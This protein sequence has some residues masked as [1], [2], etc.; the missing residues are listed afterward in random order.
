M[1]RVRGDD[2]R[3]VRC[4]N[5]GESVNGNDFVVARRAVEESNDVSIAISAAV[6]C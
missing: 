6:D 2:G 5:S 3:F 4:E 1:K